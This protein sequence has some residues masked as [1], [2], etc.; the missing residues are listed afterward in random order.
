MNG[1]LVEQPLFSAQNVNQPIGTG[2]RLKLKNK[3][4]ISL[5][6]IAGFFDGEGSIG[7]YTRKN[8]YNG[9]QLRVQL[10]QNKTKK[11]SYILNFLKNKYGGNISEQK[12]LSGKIKFNWQLNPKGV[13]IFLTDIEPYLILKK[14]QAQFALH[15]LKTKPKIRRDGKG[16]VLF[17]SKE[18][19][20]LIEET[21][22][23]MKNLKG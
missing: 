22:Q 18:E 10:V 14:T 6:Y 16:R 8:R 7:I 3:E 23:N 9:T 20:N 11:S 4:E 2:T 1:Y 17:F 21:V 5:S 13:L 12:T 19:I 15:W